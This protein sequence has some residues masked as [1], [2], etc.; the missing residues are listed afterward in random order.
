MKVWLFLGFLSFDAISSLTPLV[1][2]IKQHEGAT[3]KQ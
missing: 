1:S 2:D 3:Q